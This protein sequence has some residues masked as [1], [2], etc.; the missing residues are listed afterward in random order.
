MLG[1]VTK[2]F[3]LDDSGIPVVRGGQPY[4][5]RKYLLHYFLNTPI[6]YLQTCSIIDVIIHFNLSLAS[7]R[8]RH[9]KRRSPVPRRSVRLT[10]AVERLGIAVDKKPSGSRVTFS[11]EH[12]VHYQVDTDESSGTVTST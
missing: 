3:L 5:K 4:K 2:L 1:K 9:R 6:E 12:T 11:P 10:K 7:T 8:G